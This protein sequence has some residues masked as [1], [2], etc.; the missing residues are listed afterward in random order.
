MANGKKEKEKAAD[1]KKEKEKAADDKKEK[2]KPDKSNQEEDKIHSANEKS[3]AELLSP[4]MV[5]SL[6]SLA[7]STEKPFVFF[8]TNET[9]KAWLEYLKKFPHPNIMCILVSSGKI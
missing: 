6:P 4:L 7:P 1:G 5:T 8:I 9:H 2:K 3:E